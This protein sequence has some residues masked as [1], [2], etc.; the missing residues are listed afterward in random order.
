MTAVRASPVTS[1]WRAGSWKP[2]RTFDHDLTKFPL[3]A[4]HASRPIRSV[5]IGLERA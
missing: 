2:V 5:L 4:L 1:S 3:V